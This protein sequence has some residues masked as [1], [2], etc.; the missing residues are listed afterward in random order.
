MTIVRAPRPATHYTT[1]RNDVIRDERLSYRAVG[2][3]TFILSHSDG[4]ETTSAELSKGE[5]KEGRDAV[6][7]TL[8]ELEAAGYIRRERLRNEKGQWMTAT[9]VFDTPDLERST[10]GFQAPVF[11]AS[12]SQALLEHTGEGTSEVP[13][14]PPRQNRPS[15]GRLRGEHLDRIEQALKVTLAASD[16]R[17]VAARLAGVDVAKLDSLVTAVTCDPPADIH[18]PLGFILKRIS[19]WRAGWPRPAPRAR[20]KVGG[21][22]A[23]DFSRSGAKEWA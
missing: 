20:I 22:P 11:Q 10:T 12:V 1:I 2:L 15:T 13:P 3:L 17:K 4:W 18:E 23:G 14:Y 7:T 8:N 9:M 16:R 19:E 6:R 5:N 21:A